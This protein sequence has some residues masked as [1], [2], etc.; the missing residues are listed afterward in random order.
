MKR[1]SRVASRRG[2]ALP[3]TLRFAI[4]RCKKSGPARRGCRLDQLSPF[5]SP[6]RDRLWNTRSLRYFPLFDRSTIE[7]PI[8]TD[9][10]AGQTALSQESVYGSGMDAEML[11]Q[12]LY[13]ENFVR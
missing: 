12:F 9:A 7:P 11:R 10:K 2:R 1:V 5:T 8:A 6:A 13:R 4:R 3:A